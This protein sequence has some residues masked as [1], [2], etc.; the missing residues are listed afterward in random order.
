[1][2]QLNA[3][4]RGGEQTPLRPS[5]NALRRQ[6]VTV[7]RYVIGRGARGRPDGRACGAL[8]RRALATYKPLFHVQCTSAEVA[9]YAPDVEPDFGPS[10]DHGPSECTSREIRNVL[11]SFA[12]Q[13]DESHG[14]SR[15]GSRP[16]ISMNVDPTTS[17]FTAPLAK[18]SSGYCVNDT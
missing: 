1:M 10:Q 5:A 9:C 16:T 4:P 14:V 11:H 12:Q 2:T 13:V 17:T 18:K 3:R 6:S 7:K 8:P 15:P